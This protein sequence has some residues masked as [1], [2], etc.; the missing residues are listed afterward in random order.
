MR[1]GNRSVY[2]FVEVGGEGGPVAVIMKKTHA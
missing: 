1:C 2:L